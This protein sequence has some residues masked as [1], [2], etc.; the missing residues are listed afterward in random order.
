MVSS[1][2]R[3]KRLI[4]HDEWPQ[5][6][7]SIKQCRYPRAQPSGSSPKTTRNL[8]SAFDFPLSTIP[9]WRDLGSRENSNQ[10]PDYF[11][12]FFVLNNQ[13]PKL[14]VLAKGCYS[15][16]GFSTVVFLWWWIQLLYCYYCSSTTICTGFT[17][18]TSA[19]FP[20]FSLSGFVSCAI[21]S[22]T[23]A[24]LETLC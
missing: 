1:R 19:V 22:A 8:Q 6:H 13:I 9:N 18:T 21:S 3:R 4:W 23:T 16:A 5:S 17:L 12:S 15:L 24:Y 20:L 2:P 10:F 14:L 11:W 7:P